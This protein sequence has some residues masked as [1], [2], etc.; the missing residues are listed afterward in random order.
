[1][2]RLLII[3]FG[4]V[5][6]FAGAGHTQGISE[7]CQ[8]FEGKWSALRATGTVVLVRTGSAWA[9]G[10]TGAPTLTETP[11]PVQSF[12][13]TGAKVEFVSSAGTR[14]RLEESG[15]AMSGFLTTRT[16]FEA[17]VDMACAR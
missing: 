3:A 12:Q 17:R 13:R 7:T 5:T 4:L 11:Q 16:G 10:G 1:M 8:R 2:L 14:Y 15:R 6:L 9:L